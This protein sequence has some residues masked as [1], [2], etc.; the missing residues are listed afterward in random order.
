MLCLTSDIVPNYSIHISTTN[1]TLDLSSS[2]PVWF[3]YINS[4]LTLDHTVQPVLLI[5]LIHPLNK[6]LFNNSVL[7][8]ARLAL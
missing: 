7:P 5:I 2:F 1:P 4:V 3:Q 8:D 6:Y